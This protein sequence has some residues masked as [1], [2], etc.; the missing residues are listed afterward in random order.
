MFMKGKFLFLAGLLMTALTGCGSKVTMTVS[1][2][3]LM[4]GETREVTYTLDPSGLFATSSLEVLSSE[5]SGILAIEGMFI[6]ALNEGVATV[7]VTASNMPGADK[8]FTA[9][10][11]FTV[12]VEFNGNYIRN[13]GFE[14]GLEDW[15]LDPEGAYTSV[16]DNP[17]DLPHTGTSAFKLWYDADANETSD[18]LA[19]ELYQNPA[20]VPADTYLFSL[21]FTGDAT[22][23]I[24]TVSH[25]EDIMASEEFA[26]FGY[27]PVPEHSGYVNLGLEV[28]LDV[29]L[30]IN[31]SVN[32]SGPEGVYGFIDDVS[33]A[34][35][36]L[37]D[38][39]KAPENA[40]SGY[41]NHI[42]NGTF[43]DAEGWTVEITGTAA[44]KQANFNGGKLRIWANGAATL[45]I[46]QTV[47]LTADIYNMCIYFNGGVMDS[48]DFTADGAYAYVTQ[49]ETSEQLDLEPTGWGDGTMARIEKSDMVLSGEVEVGIYLN[50]TGGTNNWIDLDDFALWSFNIPE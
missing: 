46:H 40:E 6:E 28:T 29:V 14:Q 50:F 30:D 43:D 25:G 20:G 16:I 4:V 41:V 13:G 7:K 27:H 42:E 8:T 18:E 31:L 45:R 15:N 9:T 47:T 2:L 34:E 23:V 44:T 49:G 39:L 19:V 10:T 33:F 11:N 22:S 3:T 5:P 1:D 36:T 35:G 21:W 38:L 26:G 12:T 24:M 48:A 17:A 37:D 32:V